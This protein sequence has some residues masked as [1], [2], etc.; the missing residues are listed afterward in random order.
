MKSGA[1][2]GGQTWI[3]SNSTSMVSGSVSGF[4]TLNQAFFAGP[5]IAVR[6][7]KKLSVA[8]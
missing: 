1:D 8:S 7:W 5:S 2:C 6:L 4:E 3:M